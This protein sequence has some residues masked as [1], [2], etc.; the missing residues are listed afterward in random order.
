MTLSVSCARSMTT[1]AMEAKCS[2]SRSSSCEKFEVPSGD[3]RFALRSCSTP[4]T[5]SE[6]LR[7]G[8]AITERVR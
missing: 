8:M 2:T 5:T 7:S 4:S 3:A 6:A 1:V